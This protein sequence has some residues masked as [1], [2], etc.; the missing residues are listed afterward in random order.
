MKE[1]Q[2]PSE[3]R[4]KFITC[5]GLKLQLIQYKQK[6]MFPVIEYYSNGIGSPIALSLYSYS[7]EE[8]ELEPYTDVTVNIPNCK[9][10]TG[11]QF[12]DTNNND[13]SIIDWLE[14]NEFGKCTGNFGHSGFCTYPEFN[15]YAGKQF[16]EYKAINDKINNR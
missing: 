14:E 13:P 7:E 9:R 11:C 5:N 6:W 16:M 8:K 4:T 3:K 15:F 12:I 2:E 10:G 1:K